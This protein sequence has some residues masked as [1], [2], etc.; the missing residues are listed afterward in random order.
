[1]I[2]IFSKSIV[3]YNL[4]VLLIFVHFFCVLLLNITLSYRENK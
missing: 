1:M 3:Y 4:L 2:K